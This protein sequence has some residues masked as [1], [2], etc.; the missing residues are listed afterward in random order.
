MQ[1]DKEILG[2]NR[3][4]SLEEQEEENEDYT[5]SICNENKDIANI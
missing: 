1:L 5:T 4:P 3:E 2:T